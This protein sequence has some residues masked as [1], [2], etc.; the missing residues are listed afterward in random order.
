[1]GELCASPT[2]LRQRTF[3]SPFQGATFSVE[4]PSRRGP[5]HCGQSSAR[6]SPAHTN[7]TSTTR[8]EGMGSSVSLGFVGRGV[9]GVIQKMMQ[10]RIQPGDAVFVGEILEPPQVLFAEESARFLIGRI[11]VVDAAA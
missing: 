4:D 10:R 5:S 2:G 1:M 11:A 3:S 6:A 8:I 7:Q 9:F